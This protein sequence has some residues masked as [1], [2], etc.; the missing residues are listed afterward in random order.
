MGFIGAGAI[1]RRGNL[2]VGVTTAA[3]LWFVTVLGLCFGGGQIALGLSG[4]L[5]GIVVVTGLRYVERRMKQDRQAT[6]TVIT[7]VNGPSE[8]EIRATLTAGQYNIASCSLV[9][10][11]AGENHEFAYHL[12]WR[13]TARDTSVP[14]IVGRLAHRSGVVK[15]GWVPQVRQQ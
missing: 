4:L 6:L 10:L 14:E 5:I 13:D 11:A 15:I 8:Q 3:T 9:Y 12:N 1:V 7:T 2:V